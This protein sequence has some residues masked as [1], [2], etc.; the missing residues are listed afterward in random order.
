[1][2]FP[3]K[4]DCSESTSLVLDRKIILIGTGGGAI[5]AVK[6]ERDQHKVFGQFTSE[7]RGVV[8]IGLAASLSAA[9]YDDGH[10]IFWPRRINT[11][12]LLALPAHRGPVCGVCVA[13]DS[14]VTCGSDSTVRGWRLQ[15]TQAL[16]GKSSQEQL[17]A[18]AVAPRAPDRLS[19]VTGVRCVTSRDGL[20]F[21]GDFEGGL[22]VLR[23]ETLE[24]ARAASEGAPVI[25][26]AAH[27][28]DPIVATGGGDGCVR[29]YAVRG[30]AAPSLSLTMRKAV[31][32]GPVTSLVFALSGVVTAS[33]DGLLFMA[34]PAGKAYARHRSAE[35]FLSLAVVPSEKVVVVG[36]CDACVSLF[37]TADGTLLRQHRLS[38]SAYPLAVAVDR[39]GLF[40]A[41]A[42]SD[43]QLQLLDVF[44]GETLCAVDSH[45]GVATALA[46]HEGDLVLASFAG[47]VMRWNLP[48]AVHTAMAE[49]ECVGEPLLGLVLAE[50]RPDD[51][52]ARLRGSVMRGGAPDA[53]W[54][55]KEVHGGRLQSGKPT[56]RDTAAEEEDVADH[57]G[58]DGP[59]PAVA[60]AYEARVDD[61]VRTSFMRRKKEAA[62]TPPKAAEPPPK[63]AS[64]VEEVIVP[65]REKGPSGKKKA[66]D[67][68]PFV[69]SSE[70]PAPAVETRAD[71]IMKAAVALRT[72][73]D[74]AR[75]LL[76]AK[77]TCPE[78]VAAQGTLR[79]AYNSVRT[80]MVGNVGECKSEIRSL[81]EKILVC[82][83][84]IDS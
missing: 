63:T 22:H 6:K 74:N 34:L 71:E 29:L 47:P 79:E 11:R 40:V 28:T 1:V 4:L 50:E 24:G 8:A 43:G 73:F 82:L 31:H 64:V 69:V 25:C 33:A 42:M 26:V 68:D 3:I 20:V 12:P 7:G 30:D 53:E 65:Q 66:E 58:F 83:Q 13:G 67:R 75:R 60:G 81:T 45:A 55:F 78:E 10:L 48:P 70:R 23:S 61:I 52:D 27:R 59:R 38:P 72:A 19:S 84:Q 76:A 56:A 36:G 62:D 37:R 41:A 9:A 32:T 16:I 57:A 80:D 54:I 46:F 39:A 35:P 21:A 44:S 5:L 2:I 49:R 18:R 17:A 77:P 51:A 15:K 14:V